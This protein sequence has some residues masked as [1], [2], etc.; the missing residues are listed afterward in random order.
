MSK[1]LKLKKY[2]MPTIYIAL[3]TAFVVSAL[4]SMQGFEGNTEEKEEE[5]DYVSN[6]ILVE[7]TPVVSTEKVIIKPYT[8]SDV[9]IGKNYYNYKDNSDKQQQAIIFYE[10]SYI[11]NSGVDYTSE[12]SF[13]VISIY[14]GVVEKVED[15]E[16]VGKTVEIK[17]DNNVI[18]VY[19]SLGEVSVKVG[20]SVKSG[21]IIGKSG[22]SK[23]NSDLGNH[24][25]FEIYVNGEVLNPEDCYNKKI[26]EL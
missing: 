20:D 2:V 4:M 1:K 13:D 18:S 26:N 5:I 10:N 15:N 23:I 25:H 14:D 6:D 3:M 19:Q 8:A 16:I 9:K 22:K 21:M 12:K 7:D 24:L 11:Q 17:H